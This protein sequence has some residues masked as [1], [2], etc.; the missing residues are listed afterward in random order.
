MG[1][2]EFD[3]QP[4]VDRRSATMRVHERHF[5][6]LLRQTGNFVDSPH[7]VQALQGGLQHGINRLLDTTPNMHNQ[8][9]LY[10]TLGSNRLTSSF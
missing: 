9:R 10:F 6:T 3:L 7:L 4:F 2:F 8:D 5:I 1:T